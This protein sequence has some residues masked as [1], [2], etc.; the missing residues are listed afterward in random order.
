MLTDLQKERIRGRMPVSFHLIFFAL[1]K[2]LRGT[3]LE[4]VRSGDV[5]RGGGE[6]TRE[7]V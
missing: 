7:G 6:S 5:L 2:R 4:I 3:E 1:Q